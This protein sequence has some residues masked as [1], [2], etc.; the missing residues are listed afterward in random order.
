MKQLCKAFGNGKLFGKSD[1]AVALFEVPVSV[2]EE[3]LTHLVQAGQVAKRPSDKYMVVN[4]RDPEHSPGACSMC[5]FV[6][7]VRWKNARGD[8]MYV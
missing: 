8:G 2:S 4:D 6:P 7:M 5:M 1:V 3:A